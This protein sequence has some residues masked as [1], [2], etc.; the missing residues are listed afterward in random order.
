[1]KV[2]LMILLVCLTLA[3]S[4]SFAALANE[5][6]PHRNCVAL[7]SLSADAVMQMGA[8]GA[9]GWR[10]ESVSLVNAA[11]I[12]ASN[13]DYV[14]IEL[15]KGSTIVA[16]IDSRA[17]H[18]NGI[19]ANTLEALN[20]VSAEKDIAGSSVLT[21]NYNETDTG[22]VVALTDAMLCVQYAVK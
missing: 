20:V 2:L 9:K 10:V 15:K 17:A 12:A 11:T 3:G 7:G 6:N 14:I 16:E 22:T 21:V 5:N 19:T 4:T 18:E 1:M 8:T 13:T